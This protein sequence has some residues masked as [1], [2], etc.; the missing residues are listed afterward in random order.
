MQKQRYK[1][2]FAKKL[3]WKYIWEWNRHHLKLDQ[4]KMI[5]WNIQSSAKVSKMDGAPMRSFSAEFSLKTE[6]MTA[7]SVAVESCKNKSSDLAAIKTI[8]W[9]FRSWRGF[10]YWVTRAAFNNHKADYANMRKN[11]MQRLYVKKQGSK[12][13]KNEKMGITNFKNVCST[14]KTSIHWIT[15]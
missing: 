1:T 5:I 7:V 12:K 3:L 10:R 15:G 13:V 2:I 6:S 9:Y 8:S 11:Y 4:F 14:N